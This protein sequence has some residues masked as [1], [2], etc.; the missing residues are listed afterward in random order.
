MMSMYFAN[1][2]MKTMDK[3]NYNQFLKILKLKFTI[4]KKYLY[5]FFL[6]TTAI[7]IKEIKIRKDFTDKIVPNF[8]VIITTSQVS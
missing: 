4:K 8:L 2:D 1:I 3:Y 7:K 5:L 6:I